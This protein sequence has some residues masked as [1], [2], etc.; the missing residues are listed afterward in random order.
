V[1]PSA[2]TLV[3]PD[4]LL[5]KEATNILREYS[6]DLLFNHSI[7]VYLFGAEQGRQ[8]NSAMAG[9]CGNMPSSHLCCKVTVHKN[10]PFLTGCPFH[11]SPNSHTIASVLHLIDCS[12]RLMFPDSA[13]DQHIHSPPQAL[14][15]NK[16]ILR[17]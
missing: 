2:S 1:S 4:S 16:T 13:T 14:Q 10:E 15:E 7:R 5:A 12:Q 8:K 3:I 17:V 6:N 9:K 11:G